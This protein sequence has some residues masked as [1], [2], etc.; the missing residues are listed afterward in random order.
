MVREAL[1]KGN[2]MG[3]VITIVLATACLLLVQAVHIVKSGNIQPFFLPQKA[4]GEAAKLP[5][6]KRIG[7]VSLE[8]LLVQFFL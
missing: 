7:G 1:L 5:T 8:Y 3:V 6:A 2:A 4:R